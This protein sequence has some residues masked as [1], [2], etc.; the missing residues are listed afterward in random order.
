MGDLGTGG[1]SARSAAP[2]QT[3]SAALSRRGH[4]V[5]L[6]RGDTALVSARCPRLRTWLGSRSWFLSGRTALTCWFAVPA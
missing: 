6:R 4:P 2:V 5:R 1:A 3:E